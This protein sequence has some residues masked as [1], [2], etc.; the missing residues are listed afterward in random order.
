M[1]KTKCTKLVRDKTGNIKS[2]ALVCDN[3]NNLE[4]SPTDLCKHIKEG[5][6]ECLNLKV[7]GKTITRIIEPKEYN[8]DKILYLIRSAIAF[9]RYEELPTVCGHTCYLAHLSDNEHILYV[10]DDVNDCRGLASNI[11]GRLCGKLTVFGCNNVDN[12]SSMFEN[13]TYIEV[14]DFSY[15][16]TSKVLSM[17]KL[18]LNNKKLKYVDLSSFDTSKVKHIGDLFCHCE[19]IEHIDLST[20]DTSKV[21]DMHSMFSMCRSLKNIDL[22]GF[23]TSRVRSMKGMFSGCSRLVKLD[24]SNFNTDSVTNMDYMFSW[25]DSLIGLDLSN[26]NTPKLKNMTYLVSDCT[27]LEYLDLSSFDITNV[28]KGTWIY[29]AFE[30]CSSLKYLDISNFDF[31]KNR[32][33]P[34]NVFCFNTFPRYSPDI[35]VKVKDKKIID[36]LIKEPRIN[37]TIIG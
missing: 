21:V 10:P 17:D 5:N 37:A 34:K 3:G 27:G 25:C 36:Y 16:N 31:S 19:S 26:F 11:K 20:F 24:V 32:L 7:K 6:M 35:R 12:M 22:S 2:I 29:G 18:F 14:I 8:R 23:N 30:H 9:D 28:I 33:N 15:A 13:L 4:I 1:I